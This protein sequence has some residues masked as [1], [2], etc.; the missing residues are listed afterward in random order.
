MHIDLRVMC[1]YSFPILMKP[2][3][4]PQFFEKYSDT[5]FN[6]NPFCGSRVVPCEQT[7]GRTDKTKLIVTS[8]NFANAPEGKTD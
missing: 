6:E 7:D 8:R 3:Y 2:E 4:S 1:L 5:K